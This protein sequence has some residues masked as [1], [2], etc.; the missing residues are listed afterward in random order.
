MMG[1]VVLSDTITE[2][3]GKVR[4]DDKYGWA[5]TNGTPSRA[6]VFRHSRCVLFIEHFPGTLPGHVR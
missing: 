1:G 5:A 4:E 6:P 2:D 3:K